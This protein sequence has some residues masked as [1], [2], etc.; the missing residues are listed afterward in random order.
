MDAAGRRLQGL[1]DL[2]GHIRQAY[3]LDLG[4][5]LWDGSTVPAD[6]PPDGL[7]MAIADEGAIAALVRRP[8][9]ETLLNLW[10]TARLD[11]RGGSVFDLVARRPTV[12]TRVFRKNLDKLLTLRV[13]AKFLFVPGGGPWPL[14]GS[15]SP[16]MDGSEADNKTNVQFHYDLSN[17]FYQLFLDPEMVYSCAYYHDWSDDLATAQRSKLDMTCRRLRLQ[18][19]D[20]MLEIGS[21]W[22]A[23]LCHA[24]QHYGV[25][26]HGVT[27]SQQQYDYATAKVARLGLQDRVTIELRDYS[28][29]QGPYDKIASVGMFEHV[30]LDHHKA[31]FQTVS[32]LLRPRGLYLHHAI[33]RRAKGSDRE[34][35]KRSPEYAALVRY[36]FPG[37]EVDHIAMSIANLERHGFEVRDVEGWREHYART[38]RAWHDRLEANRAAAVREIGEAKTR[39]WLTYLAG[40]AMAFQGK[41]MGIYQTLAVKRERGDSGL[42]PTRADLY[43]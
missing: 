38:C 10:I 41:S 33:V 37:A 12:R 6:L 27:L 15:P 35:R 26:A 21:G 11:L 32:R 29:L 3:G 16:R 1:R 34:L 8:S 24:A 18:P 36:V 4:F 30:G 2:L 9:L 31:Y 5:V 22:G 17:A 23:L 25:Q 13:L 19:G 7:A 39:L 28:T 40:C 14:Q 43:R 20:R 42:P